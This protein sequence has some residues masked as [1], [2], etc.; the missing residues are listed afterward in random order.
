MELLGM[1]VGSLP[2]TTSTSDH[3]IF[4]P[5]RSQPGPGNSTRR[6]GIRSGRPDGDLLYSCPIGSALV[7]IYRLSS[8]RKI[9]R[10]PPTLDWKPAPNT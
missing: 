2:R 8:H 6:R 3:W 5:G 10:R 4:M 9:T 1:R 7:D